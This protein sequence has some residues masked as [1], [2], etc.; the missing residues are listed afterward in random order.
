MEKGSKDSK[1][2]TYSETNK[3]TQ[4]GLNTHNTDVAK[5]R[6]ASIS[7]MTLKFCRVSVDWIV[8]DNRLLRSVD[9]YISCSNVRPPA[10]ATAILTRQFKYR[11]THS[12]PCPCHAAKGLECVFP[13]WFTQCCRV[14][15]T[16]AMSCPDH[17]VLLK[18]TAQHI[19]RETTSGLPAR[20]RLLPVTTRS[21]TKVVIRS[22]PISDA[23][24]QCE[25]KHRLS[26]T[27][28][29]VVAAHTHTHT[30]RRSVKLLD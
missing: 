12:M 7:R 20:V 16:L 22:I 29:R 28:K 19:R 25:T 14:W 4:Q 15:F 26:W 6:C 21:S 3:E 5:R 30:Q 9:V 11:Y 10:M 1:A 13:I 17:A 24:G 2:Y 23:A 18:V 8:H 27:R